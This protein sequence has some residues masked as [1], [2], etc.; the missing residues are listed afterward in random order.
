[1][2]IVLLKMSTD[3]LKAT[4]RMAAHKTWLKQGFDEGVFLAAGNLTGQAGGGILA[5]GINK[6]QLMQRLTDD[7]FVANDIVTVDI[8]EIRP[9]QA[10]PRLAFLLEPRS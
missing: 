9:S 2:F 1:M 7:P 4:D 10:D 8:I 3:F 6:E 5:H